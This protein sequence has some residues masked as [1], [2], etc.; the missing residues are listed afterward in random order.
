MKCI[1]FHP[2]DWNLF[3]DADAFLKAFEQVEG[4][5]AWR[6]GERRGYFTY[7]DLLSLGQTLPGSCT[8]VLN[9]VSLIQLGQ[10]TNQYLKMVTLSFSG[11]RKQYLVYQVFNS[12]DF[13]CACILGLALTDMK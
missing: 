13:F 9:L 2:Q 8:A 5:V 4:E 12:G 3:V 11:L 7:T 1:F 6:E 10:T